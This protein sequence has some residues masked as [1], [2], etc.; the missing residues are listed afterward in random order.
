LQSRQ[1]FRSRYRFR[2]HQRS[3]DRIDDIEVN[4]FG[5]PDG[6]SQFA[7]RIPVGCLGF[8]ATLPL[9]MHDDCAGEFWAFNLEIYAGT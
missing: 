6:F 3:N 1:L 9:N 5:Q 7:L 8:G 4:C 2:A